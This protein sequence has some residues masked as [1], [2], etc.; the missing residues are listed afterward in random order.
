MYRVLSD[1][2]IFWVHF[3]TCIRGRP[4][5]PPVGRVDYSQPNHTDPPLSNL[6]IRPSSFAGII[7]G[8]GQLNIFVDLVEDVSPPKVC[9]VPSYC[10]TFPL[11]SERLR[12]P[13]HMGRIS[14]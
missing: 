6:W 7:G 8:C 4:Q 14:G 10:W 2:T 11:N 5:N 13:M 3:K 12:S 1:C 9:F